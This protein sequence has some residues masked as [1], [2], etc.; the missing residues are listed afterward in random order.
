[1]K[2]WRIGEGLGRMQL[3]QSLIK[4]SVSLG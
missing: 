3:Q 4:K 2:G 1:V